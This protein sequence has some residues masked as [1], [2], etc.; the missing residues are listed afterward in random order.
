MPIRSALSSLRKPYHYLRPWKQLKMVAGAHRT[1]TTRLP[2]CLQVHEAISTDTLLLF[3][4][5]RLFRLRFLTI[6]LFTAPCLLNTS[7]HT[8]HGTPLTTHL[9]TAPGIFGF[10]SLTT[11]GSGRHLTPP[12][13][14]VIVV[15]SLSDRGNNSLRNCIEHPTPRICIFTVAGEIVLRSPLVISHPYLTIAGQTAPSPGITISHSSLK[16]E[17]HDV[18]IQH[19]AVRPGGCPY[20]TNPSERDAISIGS[21]KKKV[22]NVVL[23]HLSATWAIDENVGIWYPSTHSITISNSIIAEG[24]HE[25]L[26]PKGPHSKGVLI[27]KGV[28]RVSILRSLLALNEERNPYIQGGTNTEF[29]NNLVY[30]WGAKGPWCVSNIS[31]YFYRMKPT[32]ASFRGNSYVAAPWSHLSFFLFAKRIHRDSK[33]YWHDN[34]FTADKTP[35]SPFKASQ[36]LAEVRT[37]HRPHTLITKSQLLKSTKVKRYVLRNTGSRPWERDAIDTRIINHVREY[38]GAIRN[39]GNACKIHSEKHLVQEIKLTSQAIIPSDLN[40]S[41]QKNGYTKLENWLHTFA[42]K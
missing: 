42:E 4:C 25:S 38:G 35:L 40:S 41:I 12:Q 28:Q 9:P 31:D 17:S 11:A 21:K 7:L 24:L 10:G 2:C 13:T 18:L 30:G 32:I 34:S 23:D 33:I 29:V 5:A 37:G 26:H 20:G 3:S 16:I 22:F 27:G 15:S 19:L 8:A 6:L 14:S 36:T 39:E 1:E